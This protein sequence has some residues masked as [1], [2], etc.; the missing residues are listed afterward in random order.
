LE[1]HI[2]LG[3]V[4]ELKH[5]IEGALIRSG[6]STIQPEHLRFFPASSAVKDGSALEIPLNL[7][8]A[9]VF[10]IKRAL[11]QSGGN[12]SEAARLL[13]VSR[14][15]LYRKLVQSGIIFDLNK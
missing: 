12:I 8:Q 4:R 5:I 11:E 9:E 15:T 10:L 14:P 6:G 13:G 3:N 1:V 2:F 7:E